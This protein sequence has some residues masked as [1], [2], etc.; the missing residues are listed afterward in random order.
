MADTGIF[1]TTAEVQRKAGLGASS[2]SSAE[3]YIND[4]MTQAESYINVTTG[5]NWSDVYSTLNID[6]RGILKEWA[7]SLAAMDVVVYDTRGYKSTA[8]V[9]LLMNKLYD[10][11]Q[12]CEA[13]MKKDGDKIK[14]VRDA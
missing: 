1:A 3:A 6:V 4:F 14:F 9:T 5:Y 7:A 11:A 2:V 8:E 10:R 13:A 12:K